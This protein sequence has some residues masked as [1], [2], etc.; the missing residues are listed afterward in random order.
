MGP[1]P[2]PGGIVS[3]VEPGSPAAAL[4]IRPGDVVLA[5]N[6]QPLRDLIDYEFYSAAERVSL[7]VQ[8]DGRELTLLGRFGGAPLGIIFTEVTF[9]GP[10]RRCANDCPFCFVKQVPPGLRRSLYIK[11]DDYR[12]SFLF[13]N[14]VTLT[15]LT[16]TDWRRLEEQRL[17]PLYVS[18]HATDPAVRAR[19]LRHSADILADLERLRRIGIAVHTQIVTVPGVN[20]GAVLDRTIADLSALPHVLSI[21]AVPVGLNERGLLV[22]ARRQARHRSSADLNLSIPLRAFTRAEARAVVAQAR[23][24][25]RRFRR[26]RGRTFAYLGDEFYLLAELPF[27]GRRHYDGFPQLEDGI[28]LTRLLLDDAARLR[29]RRLLPALRGRTATLACG[30]L[31]APVLA[32]LARELNTLAG[33]DLR[34]LPVPNDFFGRTITVSGLLTGADVARAVDAAGPAAPGP[35]FLPQSMLSQRYGVFLDDMTPAQLAERLGR[36][37]RFAQQLSSVARLLVEGDATADTTAP[38]AVY[39][40]RHASRND[41]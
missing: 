17:S 15:N 29:R 16:E 39:A 24:W 6:G 10:I 23:G 25:Q 13:G 11:D 3:A 37:V 2:V 9:D 19:I 12:Y 8:R 38:E 32:R 27:P 21:A 28:G 30:T 18:V 20:D 5:I 40:G 41:K 4:G 34:V 22:E 14:F 31:I 33:C 36:P 1:D 35:L 26:E 7:L